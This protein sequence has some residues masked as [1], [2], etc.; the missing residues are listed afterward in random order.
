MTKIALPDLSAHRKYAEQVREW[1][2]S[3]SIASAA[4]AE[5]ASL[6]RQQIQ[7]TIKDLTEKRREITDPINAGVRMVQELFRE[8]ISAL[9]VAKVALDRS[10]VDWQAQETERQRAAIAT[11]AVLAADGAPI[12]ALAPAIEAAAQP[13][14]ALSGVSYRKKIR[15]EIVDFAALPDTYKVADLRA[16]EKVAGTDIPGVRWVAEST[17]ANR[18]TK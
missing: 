1:T 12:T 4:D 8:P 7:T 18:R 2:T 10:L 11:V 14:A 9:E 6:L 15:A 16:L 17:I 13:I 3:L 5:S